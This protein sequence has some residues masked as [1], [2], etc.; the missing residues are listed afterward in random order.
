MNIA[1]SQALGRYSKGLSLGNILLL[2][3]FQL[4][5]PLPLDDEAVID[6]PVHV[7]VAQEPVIEPAPLVHCFQEIRQ[8]VWRVIPVQ[9]LQDTGEGAVD[10][11]AVY[12]PVD[13]IQVSDRLLVL[14]LGRQPLGPP[15]YALHPEHLTC[16]AL[17]PVFPLKVGGRRVEDA[18]LDVVGGCAAHGEEGHPANLEDLSTHEVEHM[19]PDILPTVPLMNRET[20]QHIEI[21]G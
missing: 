17:E 8:P 1:N 16:P 10:Q 7:V 2:L 19:G 11:D 6:H 15:G 20:V 21:V 3:T 5:H 18:I 12:L 14:L 4:H 9:L 13:P